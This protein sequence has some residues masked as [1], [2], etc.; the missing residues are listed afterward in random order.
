MPSLAF[1]QGV[2]LFLLLLPDS[3]VRRQESIHDE[4][5]C[6]YKNGS[7]PARGAL[8]RGDDKNP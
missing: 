2:Q 3:S 8:L 7:P 5:H 1:Y 6:Q 4:A